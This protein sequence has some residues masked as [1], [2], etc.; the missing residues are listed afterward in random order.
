MNAFFNVLFSNEEAFNECTE[1]R[2]ASFLS[3]GFTAMAKRTSVHTVIQ[4]ENY[5]TVII[6]DLK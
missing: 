6:G 1:V 3:G 2:F 4:I 5:A